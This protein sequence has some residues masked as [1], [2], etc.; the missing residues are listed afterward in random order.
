MDTVLAYLISAGIMCFGLWIVVAA[1]AGSGVSQAWV[2]I[3][4]ATIALGFM[5][6][7]G[8]IRTAAAA[9]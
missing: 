1:E 9:K 8:E 7:Y 3:G 2:V 5:S 6:L 4:I